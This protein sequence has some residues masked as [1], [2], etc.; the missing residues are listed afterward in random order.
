M[1]AGWDPDCGPCRP[2]GH[3]ARGLA[4]DPTVG[5]LWGLLS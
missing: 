5:S 3:M 4:Q 1:K 2:G